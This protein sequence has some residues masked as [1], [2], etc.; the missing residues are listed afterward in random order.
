M[1]VAQ[2][3]ATVIIVVVSLILSGAATALSSV[4]GGLIS[5]LPNSYF[6]LLAFRYQGALNADRVLKSFMHGELG[7]LGMTLVLFA[8]CFSLM[9]NLQELALILGFTAVQFTGV[10]ASGL[11]NY[12]PQLDRIS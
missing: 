9:P 12:G 1:I 11:I 5:A 3:L 7:K 6:A 10:V 2:L 8:L 4:A